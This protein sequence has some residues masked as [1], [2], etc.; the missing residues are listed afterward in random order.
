MFKNAAHAFDESFLEQNITS[1]DITNTVV[2]LISN[3]SQVLSSNPNETRKLLSD[4]INLLTNCEK[5]QY[6]CG[7]S[8]TKQQAENVILFID[9]H[10]DESIKVKQ[11]AD[12]ANMSTGRFS[13]AFRYTFGYAPIQFVQHYRYEKIIKLLLSTDLTLS[14]IALLCGLCDQAHLT[15]FFKKHTGDTPLKW[16]KKY[17]DNSVYLSHQVNAENQYKE[18]VHR[19]NTLL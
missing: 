6:D 1:Q 5:C 4:A 12:A 8:L 13:K 9:H 10:F 18:K 17:K 14:D 16:R 7:K 2:A 19:L 11:L 15:R 3:A